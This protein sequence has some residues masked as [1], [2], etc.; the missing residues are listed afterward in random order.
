MAD[1]E[2]CDPCL[3]PVADKVTGKKRPC[4]WSES[5]NLRQ[6]LK[7]HKF[8][9]K[10]LTVID[11]KRRFP[12]A[13]LGPSYAPPIEHVNKLREANPK[14]KKEHA[15]VHADPETPVLERFNPNEEQIQER[16]AELHRMVANDPAAKH[17]CIQAAREEDR[18]V[19]LNRQLDIA[20]GLLKPDMGQLKLLRQAC[21]DSLKEL[22]ELFNH[23]NLT[24]KE[25][26]KDNQLGGNDTVSQIMSNYANT[27]RKWSVARNELFDKLQADWRARTE[28]RIERRIL[29]EAPQ[30]IGK[31]SDESTEL[32]T[33]DDFNTAISKIGDAV[34]DIL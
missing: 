18:N 1:S 6:H 31:S 28:E 26:R 32:R 15:E 21:A 8:K 13:N 7:V 30:T 12:K 3:W 34:R 2:I 17:F 14:I 9:N 16:A 20:M 23:L 5:V 4:G 33:D 24:V 19:Q 10:A 11:Y 27:R 29:D 25:R 22:K